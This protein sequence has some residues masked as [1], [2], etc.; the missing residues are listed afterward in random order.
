VDRAWAEWVTWQLEAAGSR[1]LIQAWD[2]VGGSNWIKQMQDGV[3]LANR[4]IALLSERYLASQF[5]S[6][7]WQAVWGAD[8]QAREHLLL[9]VRVEDCDRDGLLRRVAGADLFDVDEPTARE[10]L[11]TMVDGAVAGRLKP[12]AA[13]RF[14]GA[15]RGDSRT[16]RFPGDL[17]RAWRAPSRNPHCTGRATSSRCWKAFRAAPTVTVQSVHGMGGV[18]KSQ[19]ALEYAHTHRAR[20][21]RRV[22]DGCRAGCLGLRLGDRRAGRPVVVAETWLSRR[23]LATAALSATPLACCW[24]TRC[25]WPWCRATVAA[26]SPS[27]TSC[28]SNTS[29]SGRGIVW[30]G[31]SQPGDGRRSPTRAA[32][33]GTDVAAQLDR[34]GPA[35]TLMTDPCPRHLQPLSLIM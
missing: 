12:E 9:V 27:A 6:A 14:P 28:S 25:S 3:S 21:R 18:G 22:V 11:R 4:M 7:E 26:S 8:P 24:S 19:L 23:A 16:P 33:T 2:F 13:P 34:G 15:A 17:P 29:P 1:V 35:R 5:G 32:T 20:L 30:A 31:A 10:R